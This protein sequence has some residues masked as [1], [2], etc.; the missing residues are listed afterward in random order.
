L[1]MATGT[2]PISP[3]AVNQEL[4]PQNAMSRNMMNS[5]QRTKEWQGNHSKAWHSTQCSESDLMSIY[6]RYLLSEC[7]RPIPLQFTM[8]QNQIWDQ[9]PYV[10]S[11]IGLLSSYNWLPVLFNFRSS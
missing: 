10:S 9:S 5:S 11:F 2:L 7:T 6:C 3:T 4:P 1:K 8:S